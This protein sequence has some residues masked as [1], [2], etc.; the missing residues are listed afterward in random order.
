MINSSSVA[1]RTSVSSEVLTTTGTMI[2]SFSLS[3]NAMLISTTVPV[4]TRSMFISS[5]AFNLT[6]AIVNSLF[7]NTLSSLSSVSTSVYSATIDSS[8]APVPT[9]TMIATTASVG[10]AGG[11]GGDNSTTAII[12]AAV[13]ASLFLLLLSFLGIC[14]I[15][16]MRKRRKRSH[17]NV[18][19]GK[20][21][22]YCCT[23][24]LL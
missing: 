13:I 15:L 2:I 4:I 23:Y 5:D 17:F 3:T 20:T 22:L 24:Y 8:I 19:T 21:Q 9:S 18:N 1:S 12:V 16:L 6:S 7:S 10:Q 14:I 11:D